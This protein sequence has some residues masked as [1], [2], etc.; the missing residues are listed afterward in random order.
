MPSTKQPHRHPFYSSE[1][2]SIR[3]RIPSTVSMTEEKQSGFSKFQ[4]FNRGTA[5]EEKRSG[6]RRSTST[7][8]S[9]LC[10]GKCRHCVLLRHTP[11]SD[12][13]HNTQ[14]KRGDFN[15]LD[16]LAIC[17]LDEGE[18]QWIDEGPARAAPW[19]SWP[20]YLRL[21]W[22]IRREDRKQEGIGLIQVCPLSL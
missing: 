15:G 4:C 10:S 7:D 12:D 5:D 16:G 14:W 22:R 17:A 1:A 13:D 21:Q 6:A 3:S 18:T 8:C 2:S 11:V 19:R 9:S 20:L